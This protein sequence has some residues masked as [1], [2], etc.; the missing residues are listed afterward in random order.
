MMTDASEKNANT[1]RTACPRCAAPVPADAPGGLCPR[2]LLEAS[3]PPEDGAAA[4]RA[5]SFTP[6]PIDT[7]APLLADFEVLER[8]GEGGMG[9]VYKARHK[10]LDR[11]VALKVLPPEIGRDPVLAERFRREAR[12]T[13]RL[14]HPGIVQIFDFGEAGPYCYLVLEYTERTLRQL[15]AKRIPPRKAMAILADVCDALE[16]AHL[17]GIIH[18]DLKP[19]NI[20]VDEDERLRIADFGLAKMV[21]PGIA[22]SVTATNETLGSPHYMAPEQLERPEAADHRVDIYA[23]GV[24][25]YEMLTGQ[26]PIGRFPPPSA[27]A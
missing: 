5:R 6:P 9:A 7:L 15:M 8:I 14:A 11:I 2:C 25:A 17:R 27:R 20:L 26:L 21:G 12:A 13:A 24:L 10:K 19:E 22:P 3:L 4:E 23:L 16:Y 1:T 18:R